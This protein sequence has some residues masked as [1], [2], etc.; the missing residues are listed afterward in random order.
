[1]QFL[2]FPRLLTLTFTALVTLAVAI[3]PAF[4][5]SASTVDG[6]ADSTWS[7]NGSVF[8]SVQ[9][10]NYLIIGG[11]FTSLRSK[12][13]G[14]PGGTTVKANNLAMIDTAT[15]AAVKS[16][17][18]SV[19][20]QNFTPG[21]K[22]LVR[23]LALVGNT[24]YVGGQFTSI[25]GAPHYNVGAVDID[26]TL[27]TG[28]V[29][30][31]FNATVGV[32]GDPK[33]Q[34][35]IVYSLLPGPDGLYIG[36]AFSKVDGM[37]AQKIAK[38]NWDGSYVKTFKPGAVNAAVH[39]MVWSTD[40]QTIFVGG[41]FGTFG[42]QPHWSIVRISPLT[43]KLDAWQI[44]PGGVQIGTSPHY[45]MICW[46]LVAT[47]TRL[48]A[49]CGE[50][51]NYAAAYRLDNGNSGDRAWQFN[52]PGNV[53]AIS[54]TTDGQSLIIGGHFGTYLT[55][56]VCGNKYMKNLGILHTI[57]AIATPSVD[58][59]FLPQFWGPDPF[60]GVWTIQATATQIWA[61]GMFTMDNC[62]MGPAHPHQGAAAGCP[63]GIGQRGIVRFS[64]P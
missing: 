41:A 1:M 5:A 18:P 54:L 31:T 64:P 20:E 45:G 15:G 58:C 19:L 42:G 26:P 12:P 60:G 17:H 53:Q 25:D 9:Y 10:G 38:V 4:G 6:I 44:P 7:T 40:G 23:S 49:G 51:P 61:G 43:G 30:T 63:N 57:Y 22:S 28:T 29:D 39:T 46:S 2:R 33:E 52:T 36:G 35:F 34:S 32:P 13:A 47:A 8:A 24:L 56:Q 21:I 62:T 11:D 48:F 16:F 50:T 55:M 37:G 14:V 59:S 3:V 27:L